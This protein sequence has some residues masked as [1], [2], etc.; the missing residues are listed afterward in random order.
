MLEIEKVATDFEQRETAPSQVDP[1]NADET[2]DVTTYMVEERAFTE[3]EF[4]KQFGCVAYLQEPTHIVFP[5][6]GMDSLGKW[7]EKRR[8]TDFVTL[9]KILEQKYRCVPIPWLPPKHSIA[10]KFLKKKKEIQEDF[11]IERRYFLNRFLKKIAEYKFVTD[12]HEFKVF[13][14]KAAPE[15]IKQ[16]DFTTLLKEHLVVQEEVEFE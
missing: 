8:Y 2:L 11:L 12:S 7:K 14:R 13:S 15:P 9:K 6:K 5:C 4:Q 16:N 1:K 10:T 3:T